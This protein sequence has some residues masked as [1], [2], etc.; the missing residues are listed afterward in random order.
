[1]KVGGA[2]IVVGGGGD[3][4]RM[5]NPPM[6]PGIAIMDLIAVRYLADRCNVD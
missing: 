2:R 3:P 1:V 5:N 4:S 6:A